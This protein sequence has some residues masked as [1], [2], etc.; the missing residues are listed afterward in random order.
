[1][2]RLSFCGGDAVRSGG[3]YRLERPQEVDDIL[4]LPRA[5]FIE[6]VDDL[7]GLALAALVSFDSLH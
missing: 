2:T 1:M 5:Q 3:S 7:I 6:M 4:L